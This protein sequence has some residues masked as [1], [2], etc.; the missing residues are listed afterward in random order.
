MLEISEASLGRDHPDLYD[1]VKNLAFIYRVRHRFSEAE[2]LLKRALSFAERESDPRQ[3]KARTCDALTSLG[4]LYLAQKRFREAKSLYKRALNLADELSDEIIIG[5]ISSVSAQGRIHLA[6]ACR[7]LREYAEAETLYRRSIVLLE[8]TLGTEHPRTANALLNLAML[9]CFQKRYEEAGPLLDRA[10]TI[11]EDKMESPWRRYSPYVWRARAAWGTGDR[12]LA[13]RNLRRA[14]RVALDERVLATA[15]AHERA[16]LF[17]KYRGAFEQMVVW[18]AELRN[19]DEVFA[20]VESS[21]VRELLEQMER[22]GGGFSTTNSSPTSQEF[23]RD[24]ETA[25]SEIAS[26]RRQLSALPQHQPTRDGESATRRRIL[27]D[28]L[29]N[30]EKEAA[31]VHS[32]M[33]NADPLHRLV[34]GQSRSRLSLADIQRYLSRDDAVLLEYFVGEERGYVLV[35]SA[36]GPARVQ[37]M[38][39][40]EQQSRV[41]SVPEGPVNSDRMT[42]IINPGMPP[43]PSPSSGARVNPDWAARSAALYRLLIPETVRVA[44]SRKTCRRMIVVPDAALAKLPFESLVAQPGE[45]PAYLL[46]I[47][48]PISYAPSGRVLMNLAARE[49]ASPGIRPPVLTIGNPEY[50]PPAPANA[51]GLLARL[52]PRS[53]YRGVGGTL[54]Q[55]PYTEWETNWVGKVFSK[56]RVTA[57]KLTGEMATERIVRHNVNDRRIVH[58]ACHGLVDQSYGNLFGALAL[59]PG[60]D[61]GDPT[62]DG[63]LTL[64]EIYD[65]N[66]DGC[67]L[68][69]LSAC[70]TNAGPEQRGEGTWALSRGFLVAG[71]RRVVASN[72]LVDDEA[73]ASLVSYFCSIIAKAEAKGEQPD[74]AKALWKA[75]RWVRNHPDHPEWKHPYYWGTFVLVGPN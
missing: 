25:R 45:E 9:F 66:L 34:A 20:V 17:S 18:Q 32:E 37:E 13:M 71:A 5:S 27:E 75:K 14:I 56:N 72:W 44:L 54:P 58:F 57:A 11:I 4:H 36:R 26:L 22:H 10:I 65:L 39:L 49:S 15:V 52:T 50:G 3:S 28:R 74:Y 16:E 8:A 33:K 23:R 60:R 2:V 68:A 21:L 67:E 41:L 55:L 31:R 19:A 51:Q 29:R 69:I 43:L 64:A 61:P 6:V 42:A 24:Y 48:P 62:N 12:E 46:D 73:A 47:G 1:P 40:D 30:A 59:T 63:F 35:V 38:C 53:R 7:H 70:D